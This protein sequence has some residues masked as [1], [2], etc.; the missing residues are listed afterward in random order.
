MGKD[1]NLG[2][3]YSYYKSGQYRTFA[4]YEKV[5]RGNCLFAGEHF[6]LDFQS[7][8]EGGAIEGVRAGNDIL[9]GRKRL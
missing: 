1:P 9:A 8:M 4:L 3:A 5:R 2:P 7:L 6:S